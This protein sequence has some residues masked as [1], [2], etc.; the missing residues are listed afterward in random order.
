MVHSDHVR[1]ADVVIKSF[2]ACYYI[3]AFH[4]MKHLL[5]FQF[6]FLC[7][8]WT[9]LQTA[10]QYGSTDI[11][12]TLLNVAG[13]DINVKVIYTNLVLVSLFSINKVF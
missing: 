4:F 1:I 7:V 9:P 3:I 2:I 5:Y 10:A 8:G 6:Y 11:L 13:C 12:N